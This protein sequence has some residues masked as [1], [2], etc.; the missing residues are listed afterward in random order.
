MAGKLDIINMAC[1][2]IHVP[3]VG[4]LSDPTPQA[5]IAA[6]EFDNARDAVLREHVWAFATRED[7]LAPLHIPENPEKPD[8]ENAFRYTIPGDCLFIQSVRDNSGRT[9]KHRLADHDGMTILCTT[10]EAARITFTA[11]ITNTERFDPVFVDA[12]AWRLAVPMATGIAV[13]MEKANAAQSMYEQA[14]GRGKV[15]DAEEENTFVKPVSSYE[16]GRL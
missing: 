1:N 12:L 5:R 8:K 15:A 13:D 2:R 7:D 14:I 4:S 9:I 6:S 11:R 3:P 10:N 16:K